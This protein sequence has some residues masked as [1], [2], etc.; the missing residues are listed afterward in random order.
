MVRAINQGAL[1]ALLSVCDGCVP[2]MEITGSQGFWHIYRHQLMTFFKKQDLHTVHSKLQPKLS[3]LSNLV[4]T[5]LTLGE[6]KALEK[7]MRGV[8]S[9]EY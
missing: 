1:Q 4:H 5:W 2:A 6:N 9:L 3:V 7:P 8:I